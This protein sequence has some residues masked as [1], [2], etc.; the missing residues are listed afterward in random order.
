MRSSPSGDAVVLIDAEIEVIE[1]LTDRLP[2]QEDFGN[3]SNTFD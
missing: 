1:E 2:A 3:I